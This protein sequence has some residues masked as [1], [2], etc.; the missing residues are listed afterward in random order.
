MDRYITTHLD[1]VNIFCMLD[2]RIGMIC[3][4]SLWGYCSRALVLCIV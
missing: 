4:L 3:F 1:P 2:K